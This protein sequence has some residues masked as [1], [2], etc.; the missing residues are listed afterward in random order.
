MCKNPPAVKGIIQD[1]RASMAEVTPDPPMATRAPNSPAPA[2]KS[3]AR[4][5]SQRENP[6]RSS[7]AKSPTSCGISCTKKIPIRI[8]VLLKFRLKLSYK[9]WQM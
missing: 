8:Y 9:E 2:V 3:C 7:M 6:E 5:A 1:V 4:A